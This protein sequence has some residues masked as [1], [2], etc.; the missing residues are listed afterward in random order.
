MRSFIS[1]AQLFTNKTNNMIDILKTC[2][3][4]DLPS[5][6]RLQFHSPRGCS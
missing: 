3:A 1:H 2:Q 5:L 6:K 4:P